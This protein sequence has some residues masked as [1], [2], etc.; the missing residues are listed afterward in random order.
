MV[1]KMLS[2]DGMIAFLPLWAEYALAGVALLYI[3]VAGGIVVSKVG[4]HPAW[5]LAL[6]L[7]Y[8]QIVFLYWLAFANWPAEKPTRL[9]K[10]SV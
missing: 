2:P 9:D 8:A 10:D 1:S 7:P 3:M 6:L 4:R 5:S